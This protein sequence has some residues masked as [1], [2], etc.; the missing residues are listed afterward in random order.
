MIPFPALKL[1]ECVEK[2]SYSQYFLP[3][4]Q[5]LT[6]AFFSYPE[7]VIHRCLASGWD[8]CPS[9]CWNSA[10]ESRESWFLNEHGLWNSS[11]TRI[12]PA[13][14]KGTQL[15]VAGDPERVSGPFN[16]SQ[17][18]ITYVSLNRFSKAKAREKLALIDLE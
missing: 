7:L 18:W 8:F 2:A 14:L 4:N 11:W 6:S 17:L 9:P 3:F 15:L 13:S 16:S 1:C 10:G 5:V 12:S